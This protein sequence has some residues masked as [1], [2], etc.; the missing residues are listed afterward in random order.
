[1]VACK[2]KRK[3]LSQ[4]LQEVFDLEKVCKVLCAVYQNNKKGRTMCRNVLLPD[5]HAFLSPSFCII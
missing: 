3:I 5:F 1:M 4:L 2:H